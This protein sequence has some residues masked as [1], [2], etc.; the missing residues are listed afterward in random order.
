MLGI[1]AIWAILAG[2][3]VVGGVGTY[4]YLENSDAD[5]KSNPVSTNPAIVALEPP[6][7]EATNNASDENAVSTD[8]DS[9]GDAVTDN[10]QGDANILDIEPTKD[11]KMPAFDVL[12]VEPDGSTVIAGKGQPNT[13]LKVL[14]GDEVLN[15]VKVGSNGDFVVIF[16]QP[17][18]SGDYQLTLKVED[19]DGNALVSD[20]TA[21]VSVP[22]EAGG[23]LL[24]MV[25]KPGKA[26]RI[27]AQPEVPVEV[28][29][30]SA[31]KA[32]EEVEVA[33]NIA[34][35][36]NSVDVK[37]ETPVT[38]TD[39]PEAVA[40]TS[41][42]KVNADDA[43]VEKETTTEMAKP[44]DKLAL[45]GEENANAG[46]EAAS[47]TKDTASVDV[48]M[49][50]ED[51]AQN[52]E[53]VATKIAEIAKPDTEVAAVEKNVDVNSQDSVEKTPEKVITEVKPK[54]DAIVR[55]EAVEVEGDK[56]FVAGI[57]SKGNTVR[58][59]VDDFE[60]GFVD[61]NGDGRFLIETQQEL[62]VGQHMITAALEDK[63]TKQIVLRAVVPFDR[64]EAES[65]AAIAVN[66]T[67]AEKQEV[68]V[69]SKDNSS[70][71]VE[72]KPMVKTEIA[73]NTA[74]SEMSEGLTEP[75]QTAAN[76]SGNM[77]EPKSDD[78]MKMAKDDSE[79]A[80]NEEISKVDEME[81][82]PETTVAKADV[83]SNMAKEE[84]QTIVQDTLTPATSQS[85]II[86]KGD[87]LWQIA[88]RTYGAG[89]RYTTIYLANQEQILNPDKI[90]PGQIFM[91]PDEA[92]ENAEEL[93]LKRLQEN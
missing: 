43:V 10:A 56:L 51:A 44:D 36:E 62:S 84:P 83:E 87:T 29:N 16:D 33:A 37:P 50:K 53:D 59:L 92:L 76:S 21:I 55:I 63:S 66:D 67:K 34:T 79:T 72:D 28:A 14:N 13:I 4:V 75:G 42:L 73:S 5:K 7:P 58:I 71:N 41:E 31:E 22:E 12:R 40:D 85:V 60:V 57:A 11:W 48:E 90:A 61:V 38:S 25:T 74:E 20:E 15:E 64:P 68:A 78:A 1:K 91:V 24:A 9:S 46:N 70:T 69:A 32:D 52:I 23:Q 17:L 82:K 3:V 86:R 54:I 19:E 45:A 65:A 35:T 47:M 89:V 2:V 18:D 93:H 39:K 80:V 77:A 49:V 27:L 81:A 6:E 88:R 30:E 8:T 26:S